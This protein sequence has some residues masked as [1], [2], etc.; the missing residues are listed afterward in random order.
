MSRFDQKG[1]LHV[2]EVKPFMSYELGKKANKALAEAIASK[3]GVEVGE[4]VST[5]EHFG[6]LMQNYVDVLANSSESGNRYFASGFKTP[7][8]GEERA[9]ACYCA[10]TDILGQAINADSEIH[11]AQD[12]LRWN[13]WQKADWAVLSNVGGIK[14]G[15]DTERD[16]LVSILAGDLVEGPFDGNVMDVYKVKHEQVDV[17]M[18][19]GVVVK[20][21]RKIEF[22]GGGSDS[23]WLR[24]GGSLTS[25]INRSKL[26]RTD[27]HSNDTLNQ[28]QQEVV[29]KLKSW[30]TPDIT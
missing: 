8:T 16:G 19:D 21:T 26:R 20:G 29:S 23:E 6:D 17:Q 24:N 3:A 9:F 7:L 2:D 30:L 10:V 15:T 11:G 22:L 13:A 12:K 1:D 14:V 28:G 18:G 5:L 4:V 27:M 25:H